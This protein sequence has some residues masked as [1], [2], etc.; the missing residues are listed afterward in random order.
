MG[1]EAVGALRD[2][3]FMRAECLVCWRKLSFLPVTQG[4][5]ATEAA[6]AVRGAQDRGDL[7][8]NARHRADAGR[9]DTQEWK[10]MEGDVHG[11]Q[12]GAQG[13]ARM[14]C[15]SGF[16]TGREDH[17][18]TELAALQAGKRRFESGAISV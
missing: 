8:R 13:A 6:I 7:L 12:P 4:E 10:K 17:C 2:G 5:A 18:K 9:F 14:H 15:R 16:C 3:F 1:T 11:Q